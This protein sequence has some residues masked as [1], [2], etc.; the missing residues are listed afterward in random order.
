[1]LKKKFISEEVTRLDKLPHKNLHI[2]YSPDII[3]V[4]KSKRMGSKTKE[5]EMV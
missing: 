2:F 4:M 3:R 1:M 5:D